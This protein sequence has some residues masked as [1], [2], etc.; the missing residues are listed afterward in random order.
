MRQTALPNGTM[1]KR[2]KEGAKEEVKVTVLLGGMILPAWSVSQ[3]G[4]S[5][6]DV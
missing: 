6:Q 3:M 4:K 1:T 5:S 2:V